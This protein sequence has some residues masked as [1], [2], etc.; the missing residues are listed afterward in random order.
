MGF[1]KEVP[2]S[3]TPNIVL[4]FIDDLGYGDL[5]VTGALGYTTPNLDKMAAEGTRF[6]NFMAAQDF[7]YPKALYHLTRDPG[8]RYDVLEQNPEIVAELE[9]IADA[10]REDMGDDLQQ[11]QGKNVRPVGQVSMR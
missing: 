5:S 2:A 8:E 1:K 9:K 7:Q 10:A 3:R 6:T 11:K 4:F